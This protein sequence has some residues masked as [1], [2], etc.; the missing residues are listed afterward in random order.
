MNDK[1]NIRKSPS[2]IEA[3]KAV[4]GCMLLNKEAV[5]KAVQI[6]TVNSFYD[7]SHK[8]IFELYVRYD[9]AIIIINSWKS[10]WIN[11]DKRIRTKRIL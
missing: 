8:I 4:L 2:S 3:E 1:K 9:C 11:N 10:C 5:Y 7:D 6:L